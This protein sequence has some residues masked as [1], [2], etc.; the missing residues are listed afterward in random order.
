[1]QEQQKQYLKNDLVN[2]LVKA[3]EEFLRD[4][5]VEDA[6]L[7]GNAID[8]IVLLENSIRELGALVK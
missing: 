2:D 4:G 1:M 3:R 8:R 7:V 5:Y 6:E